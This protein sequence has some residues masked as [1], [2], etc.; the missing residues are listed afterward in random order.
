MFSLHNK[1]PH[2]GGKPIYHN[3]SELGHLQGW[4]LHINST[5]LLSATHQMIL[6]SQLCFIMLLM[7][8]I[9]LPLILPLECSFDQLQVQGALDC[10]CLSF[11]HILCLI[12]RSNNCISPTLLSMLPHVTCRFCIAFVQELTYSSQLVLALR[13]STLKYVVITA[14]DRL[15]DGH[16][17]KKGIDRCHPLLCKLLLLCQI[18]IS[19]NQGW[20][21]YSVLLLHHLPACCHHH[22]MCFVAFTPFPGFPSLCH[23]TTALWVVI[24]INVGPTLV[25]SLSSTSLT[26]TC[27]DNAGVNGVGVDV[28][29]AQNLCAAFSWDW[30]MEGWVN[31]FACF[32]LV[33]I[34][35]LNFVAV[36]IIEG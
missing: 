30:E 12:C 9:Y 17:L 29:E 16:R 31:L 33:S 18:L 22:Q 4:G 21:N 26:D 35:F 11:L 27:L 1:C 2:N 34:A 36:I 14:V 25:S 5:L 7:R 20:M 6:P 13:C 10:C 3:I 24:H 8:I 28:A 19:K 32:G 23:Q 15:D